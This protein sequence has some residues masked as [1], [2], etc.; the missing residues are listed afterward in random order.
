MTTIAWDGKTL[1]ADS[2]CTGDFTL[3]QNYKKIRSVKGNHYGAC[4]NS[5]AVE[6]YF[7]G[8]RIEDDSVEILEVTSSGRLRIIGKGN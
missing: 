1:A 3:Q 6:S 7:N 4:G 8:S 2:R 5:I